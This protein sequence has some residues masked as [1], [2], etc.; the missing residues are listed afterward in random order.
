MDDIPGEVFMVKVFMENL[1][2]KLVFSPHLPI[3]LSVT[4]LKRLFLQSLLGVESIHFPVPVLVTSTSR[5]PWVQ[6]RA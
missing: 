1:V 3:H 2:G 6:F 4:H 5:S